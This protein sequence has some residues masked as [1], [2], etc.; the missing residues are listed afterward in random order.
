MSVPNAAAAVPDAR[1]RFLLFV[2]HCSQRVHV[3][4]GEISDGC[5]GVL[6]QTLTGNA[7]CRR[8]T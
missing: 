2:T 5:E 3:P 7:M 1:C 6:L 4:R 8:A